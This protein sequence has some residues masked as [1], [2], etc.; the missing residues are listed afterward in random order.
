MIKAMIAIDEKR[1]MANDTEIP[2]HLPTDL[3]YYRD[4]TRG[5]AVL[6]GYGMYKEFTKPFGDRTSYV[7]TTSDEPLMEGFHKVKDAYKFLKDYKG[8]IW[9]LGGAG[10]FATTFDL[11]DELYLTQLEGDFGCT[12]FF[13]EYKDA[14]EL[15]SES[16]P[17]EENGIKFTFQVWKRTTPLR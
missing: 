4:Q 17:Q 5:Q 1:G 7:A 6:M 3:Q 10:L 14:F 8:D 2:W 12:K 16:E 15:V 11:V 9:H 13:P